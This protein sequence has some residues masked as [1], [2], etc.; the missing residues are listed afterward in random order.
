[1]KYGKISLR[2][3]ADSKSFW[4]GC[5]EHHLRLQKCRNCGFVRWPLSIICPKCY[6]FNT[7]W[8]AT[9]GKG[10]IFSFVVYHKAYHKAFESEVPY[11]VGSVDLDEGPRIVTNIVGCRPEE[12]K[13]D[14][15]VEVTWEDVD[16]D[17]SLPKFK[18]AP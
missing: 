2:S 18:L 12:L 5:R 17:F 11:I 15:R 3:N 14:M 10:K 16:E 8:T 1:M 6:S 7:D 4:D 9:T 13:C